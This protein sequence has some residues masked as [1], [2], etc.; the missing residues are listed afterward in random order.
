[1]TAVKPGIISIV[2]LFEGTKRPSS[3]VIYD[4]LSTR[5]ALLIVASFQIFRKLNCR[6]S[7]MACTTRSGRCSSLVLRNYLVS[8]RNVIYDCLIILSSLCG[9]ETTKLQLGRNVGRLSKIMFKMFP[10]S[11][12]NLD[13]NKTTH[14][15][16]PVT[17]SHIYSTSLR[18]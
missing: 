12:S 2:L 16:C 4:T 17:V 10:F 18:L 14:F 5:Q 1:M 8:P 11:L 6:R 3:I 15:L 7:S 9:E 13:P